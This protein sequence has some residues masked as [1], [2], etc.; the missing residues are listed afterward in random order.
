MGTS[1][2]T[3]VTLG[4]SFPGARQQAPPTAWSLD[5]IYRQG[6]QGEMPVYAHLLL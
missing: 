4:A 6:L 2:D 1:S 5:G 3:Y